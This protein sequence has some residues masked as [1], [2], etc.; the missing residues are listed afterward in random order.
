LDA[1]GCQVYK[2]I[3]VNQPNQLVGSLSA[4]D[5]NCGL[6]NGSIS[7]NVQGGTLPYSYS[8]S[9]GFTSPSINNLSSGN[10]QLIVLDAN[11]CS[12]S[13]SESLQLVLNT[14][15]ICLVSVDE[16]STHNQIV[17]EHPTTGINGIKQYKVYRSAASTYVLV[18]SISSLSST[19]YTDLTPGI[20]PNSTQYR[21]K[22][23]V[24]DSCGNESVKSLYHQTI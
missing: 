13:L 12:L 17:W 21:Y 16:T 2:Q 20:N 23:T 3:Q 6:F 4:Q 1:S 11:L 22:L 19:I 9:N 7:S 15:P 24:I 5:V 10:Y 8:W 18:D 14:Q